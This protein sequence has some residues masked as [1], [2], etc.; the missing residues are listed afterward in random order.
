MLISL[1]RGQFLSLK[2]CEILPVTALQY[3]GIICDPETMT[4]QI[5]QESL[6]K[7]H[8][9]LQTA[10]ADGC[11]SYRTLQRVAGKYMNM[12]VAIRPASVWTH[13]MFAV[14]PAMDKTNQRQVD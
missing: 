14:L 5:T 6:D 2:K 1:F 11:V 9:F 3:L 12:T 13:A 4:F 7:P 8:D 10:L